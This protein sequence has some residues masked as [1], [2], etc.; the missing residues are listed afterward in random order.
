MAHGFSATKEMALDDYA[1]IICG[2]GVAVLVHDHAHLGE[3]DGEPRQVVDPWIQT[4]GYVA[5][6]DWLAARPEVDAGR[7]G[8][9]GSSFS[10]GHVLVLGAL[11]ERVGAVVANV[12]FVGM[13]RNPDGAEDRFTAMRAELGEPR[14]AP[15]GDVVGPIAPVNGPGVPADRFVAMPEPEAEE[16][17][18]TE[19][20]RPPARWRNEVWSPVPSGEPV[21]W[22]PAA[23]VPH[24]ACATLYV[25]TTE[26]ANAP[27]ADALAAFELT[28]TPKEM[29][30]MSGHH[31]APYRGEP[32]V[33]A[34]TA[35]RDFYRRWL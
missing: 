27:D 21:V 22:D 7:L 14:H 11:D 3:S 31:F 24:L 9:W 19:G 32:L 30:V 4:R 17:F 25:A 18:T 33:R 15:V 5:A 20:T 6:L 23:A 16:W 13:A 10:G 28:P 8:A 12:P 26:D 1:E 34:A 29:L 2:G 35:A